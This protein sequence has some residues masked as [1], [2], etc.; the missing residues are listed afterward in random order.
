MIFDTQS[1][2]LLGKHVD[3]SEPIQTIQFSPDGAMVALGSRDNNIYIYQ[4]SDD[5][6][7]YSRVGKCSVR[8][9]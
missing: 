8:R 1:R 7:K 4:V 5:G 3:G 2:D 6:T 9:L